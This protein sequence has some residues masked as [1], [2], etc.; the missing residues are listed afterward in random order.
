MISISLSLPSGTQ[1]YFDANISSCNRFHFTA[2]SNPATEI[3][4][5]NGM[6]ST[7]S[8]VFESV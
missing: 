4:D 6:L 5:K 1:R 2:D 3:S 8:N 7:Q